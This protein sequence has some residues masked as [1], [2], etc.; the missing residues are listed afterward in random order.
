MPRTITENILAASSWLT[1]MSSAIPPSQSLLR[2]F[3]ISLSFKLFLTI[4]EMTT[5][6]LT[7]VPGVDIADPAIIRGKPATA[8]IPIAVKISPKV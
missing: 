7:K 8:P 5:P 2:I 1:P 6:P 3:K 4:S